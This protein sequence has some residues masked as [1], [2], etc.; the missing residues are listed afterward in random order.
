M[1]NE[2]W[3]MMQAGVRDTGTTIKSKIRI[4]SKSKRA[5]EKGNSVS[6]MV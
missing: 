1:G 5:R 3:G 6:R 2:E 4:E